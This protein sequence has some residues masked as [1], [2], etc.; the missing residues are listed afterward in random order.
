MDLAEPLRFAILRLSRQ[1]RREAGKVGLSAQDAT[2]LAQIGKQPGVGVCELAD[3]EGTSRPTMS[4][5][6][7]RLEGAAFVVRAPR[8]D[9]RRRAGL[10]LTPTGHEV[11]AALRKERADWMARRLA[12]LSAAERAALE[13]AV[14]ALTRLSEIGQ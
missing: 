14:P 5:H 8:S 12:Q 10:T 3:L 6:M 2:L 9:D 1:L 4:V 11:L 13:A 7:T